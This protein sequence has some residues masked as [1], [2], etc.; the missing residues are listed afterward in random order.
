VPARPF[1]QALLPDPARHTL[2][3]KQRPLQ[4]AAAPFP[5]LTPAFTAMIVGW[6]NDPSELRDPKKVASA[7]GDEVFVCT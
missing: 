6:G 2:R 4:T 5:S 7:E 3:N 1:Q